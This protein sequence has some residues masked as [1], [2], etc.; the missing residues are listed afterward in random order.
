MKEF[1]G[2]VAGSVFFSNP[3]RN[4]SRADIYRLHYTDLFPMLDKIALTNANS[5]DPK[6]LFPRKK[7]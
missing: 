7:S 4:S 3:W 2:R 5:I 1:E 6:Q